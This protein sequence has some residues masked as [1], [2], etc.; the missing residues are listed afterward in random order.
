MRMLG[1]E[2]GDV[3]L[4]V[5]DGLGLPADAK[6]AYAFAVLGFLTVHGLPGTDALSTGARRPSVLGSI[7]PG[8]RGLPRLGRTARARGRV[9]AGAVARHAFA[10]AA[11]HRV[12]PGAVAHPV[13]H[14]GRSVV[15]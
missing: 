14:R 8:H 2:L 5:A 6:E 7:T 4:R 1:A 15:Q 9:D 3:P 13:S 11:G 10:G 12:S